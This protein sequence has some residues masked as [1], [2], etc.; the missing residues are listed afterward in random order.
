MRECILENG[1][2]CNNCGACQVCDLDETK[3]CDNCCHHAPQDN[4]EAENEK[5]DFK[6]KLTRLTS[7]FL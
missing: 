6:K 7:L 5:S 2:L 1:K 3:I 4:D